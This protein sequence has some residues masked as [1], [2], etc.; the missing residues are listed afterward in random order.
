MILTLQVRYRAHTHHYRNYERGDEEFERDFRRLTEERNKGVEFKFG[1]SEWS[2]IPRVC[3]TA[4][5]VAIGGGL[6]I[7]N[8]S[9]AID[10][11]VR[12]FYDTRVTRFCVRKEAL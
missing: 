4:L 6:H 5:T 3:Q 7:A 8:R 12:A 1:D 2:F 9:G 11:T 10:A